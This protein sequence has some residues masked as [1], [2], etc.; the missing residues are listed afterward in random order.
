VNNG[1][2]G[3]KRASGGKIA[4]GVLIPLLFVL[5]LVVGAYVKL[6]RERGKEDRKRWSEAIDSRMSTISTTWKPISVAGAQAA[7]RNSIA[8]DASTRASSFSFGNIRPASSTVAVEGGQAGIGSRARTVLPG[9]SNGSVHLRSSATSSQIMA[10]R[11]SRISFAPDVRASSE[12]RRTVASRAFHTAII[13][14]LPDPEWEASQS[15]N[16]NSDQDETLS[17]TQTNGPEPLSVE[18][19]Q[20]RLA[21]ETTSHPSVDA[22]MPALRMMRTGDPSAETEGEEQPELLFSAQSATF[23]SIPSPAHSLQNPEP[24]SAMS[25]FMPMQPMH[26]NVMSPDD[27]LRAYAERR[28]V[29]GASNV[30][31]PS[32]PSPTYAGIGAQG[33]TRNLYSPTQPQAQAI[34]TDRN[35][36]RATVG[37]VGSQYS[38]FSVEDAYGGTQ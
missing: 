23:P 30:K 35:N 29:G 12:T 11:V 36:K 34:T 19:I 25:T 28:A 8:G 37:T 9:Q 26:A 7:I 2:N 14:P 6:K 21:G 3:H 31:G 1:P 15:P 27:L 22:V 32:I 33:G 24:P 13:P 10:E 18:D 20:A 5:F 16:R 17:P 38:N 4:A